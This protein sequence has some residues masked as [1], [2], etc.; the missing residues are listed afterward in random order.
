MNRGPH[1]R[2]RA[3]VIDSVRTLAGVVSNNCPSAPTA[4]RLPEIERVTADHV[5]VAP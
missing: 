5:E 1:V 4:A 3:F 2:N